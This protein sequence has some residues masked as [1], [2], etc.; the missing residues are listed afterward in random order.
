M[1][2][3]KLLSGGIATNAMLCEM[4]TAIEEN[5]ALRNLT[6]LALLFE[7]NEFSD[8][9]AIHPYNTT[10]S[11]CEPLFSLHSLEK[12]YIT[13]CFLRVSNRDIVLASHCWPRIQRLRLHPGRDAY[14]YERE[15]S[16]VTP[17]GL[18]PLAIKCPDLEEL[19]LEVNGSHI[20]PSVGDIDFF[21]PLVNTKLRSLYFSIDLIRED[22]IIP[23]AAF[24]H[25][26]LPA[27][28]CIRQE[29][30]LDEAPNRA[31]QLAHNHRLRL[32]EAVLSKLTDSWKKGEQFIA[33]DAAAE[34][35]R[36]YSRRRE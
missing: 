15:S 18:I 17:S 32:L 27:L 31:T 29:G 7:E 20:N 8:S 6:Y 19:T 11:A 25:K 13:P 10:F 33:A 12:L 14:V 21:V 16:S 30:S 26:I 22:C 28:S 35:H 2:S 1:K 5:V 24:L 23:L 9:R 34:F 36:H 3:L 4:C